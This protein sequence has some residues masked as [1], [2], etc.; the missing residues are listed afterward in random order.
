MWSSKVASRTLAGL[1]GPESSS[2]TTLAL[3][4]LAEV[5]LNGGMAAFVDADHALDPAYF[6]SLGV[7]VD[8]LIVSQPDSGEMTLD[9][10]DQLVIARSFILH[11]RPFHSTNGG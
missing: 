4:K 7:K 9:I 1:H 11:P 5:Q 2:K 6:K 10:V 8:A 3:H